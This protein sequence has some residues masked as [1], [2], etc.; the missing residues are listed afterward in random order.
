MIPA[1]CLTLRQTPERTAI[2]ESHFRAVGVDAVMFRGVHGRTW[3]IGTEQWFS[4]RR[5]T[6][7][8]VIPPGHIGL[9]LSHWM[10]WSHLWHAGVEEALVLEDDAILPPDF[11]QQLAA[12][13]AALPDDWQ[14]LSVGSVGDPQRQPINARV[15]R[16]AG[17]V[18]GTHAYLVRRAALPVLLDTMQSCQDH[19]DVQLWRNAMPRLRWYLAWPSL[20]QQRTA[21]GEW[22]GCCHQDY[23][24]PVAVDDR[25]LALAASAALPGWCPPEKAGQIYDEVLRIGQRFSE[26]LRCV[27]LG[28]WHGKSLIP[29]AFALRRLGRGCIDGIDPYTKAAAIE[30][31]G[32][33]GQEGDHKRAWANGTY[34]EYQDA[35]TGCRRAI[36]Q[37]GLRQYVCLL[38]QMPDELAN[39]Y[40]HLHYL[41]VDDSH[42]TVTSVRNVKTWLPKLLPGGVLVLDDCEWPTV[43]PARQ[44]VL[45]AFGAPHLWDTS[46]GRQWEI[47]TA[48]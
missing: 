14:F 45:A 8:W 37:H 32:D 23:R 38:A 35:L 11:L 27:E 25:A 19:I 34:G 28:V 48:R 15:C 24:P 29:A 31:L 6:G 12:T 5:D 13:R 42:S 40:D 30:G 41:H 2:A 7:S 47:Y 46:P 22:E 4:E 20:A 39:E 1:Y 43:Q 10:L 33:H 26:P 9:N 36:D 16:V 18:F 44:I 21:T 17:W 3:G